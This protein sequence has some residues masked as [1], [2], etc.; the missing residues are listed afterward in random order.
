MSNTLGDKKRIDALL[1]CLKEKRN[2]EFCHRTYAG[3]CYDILANHK[4]IPVV[5]IDVSEKEVVNKILFIH[6]EDN[7]IYE[8]IVDKKTLVK[9]ID[10]KPE[11]IFATPSNSSG[12]VPIHTVSSEH[13]RTDA[14][15]EKS[16]NLGNLFSITDW[17]HSNARKYLFEILNALG[18]QCPNIS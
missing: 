12:L 14:N 9:H 15:N 5:A 1:N 11:I 18:I 3:K 8:K 13:L 2:N 10:D 6:V 4:A 17:K 7:K 16:D